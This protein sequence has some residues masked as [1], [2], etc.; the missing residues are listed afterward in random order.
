MLKRLVFISCIIALAM[1]A[2]AQ[3]NIEGTILSGNV[4]REY[5]LH[6]PTNY[7][8]GTALPLVLIFHG[9]GGNDKQMQRYMG[10]DPIAD[11]ENFITVY[12]SGINK[13]WNDGREFKESIAANDDVQFINLLLDTLLK[14]YSIDSSRL[15]TT[16]ISNG[17]FFSIYLSYKLNHRL[18][19][20]APVCAS[21]PERIY[22]EF[23]PPR[24]VSILIMNGTEDPLVPYRGGPVGNRFTG[25]R[26]DCT[27]TD[28]TLQ[29]YINVDKTSATPVVENLP[30]R[31]KYDRCTVVKYMYSGGKNGTRVCLVKVV[32]GGHA[33]PGGSQYLPK[34]I[35]GRACQDFEGNE[36]IWEFFKNCPRR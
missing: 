28:S 5:I 2:L 33:L 8:T 12:P 3:K 35:I 19:A 13:Q 36:M 10:M 17:G 15:F 14:K 11:R 25:S 31:D 16:G 4:K 9:G 20:A 7:K 22:S 34:I 27:S 24:P 26:G 30:D 1:G 32:N 21:I 29:R 18:L 23:Y 6:L